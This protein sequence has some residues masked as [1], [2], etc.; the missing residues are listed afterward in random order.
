MGTATTFS[1]LALRETAI[2]IPAIEIRWQDREA[3][4][5]VCRTS[6]YLHR[7]PRRPPPWA[8]L[9]P[10]LRIHLEGR[11]G[12][13]SGAHGSSRCSLRIGP[14][15]IIIH[16]PQQV[17]E[18]GHQPQVT[19]AFPGGRASEHQK[20]TQA[21]FPLGSEKDMPS[22]PDQECTPCSAST[23]AELSLLSSRHLSALPWLP[24]C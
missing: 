21:S 24:G 6:L 8:F 5:P 3:S 11:E 16:S 2:E 20:G 13:P 7:T 19:S 14:R 12:Q 15:G 10:G 9:C 17:R 1:G 4:T 18:T 22:A 23:R